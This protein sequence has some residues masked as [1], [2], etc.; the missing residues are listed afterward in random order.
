L[1]IR[2]A[3]SELRDELLA[4]TSNA[5]E[6]RLRVEPPPI[7]LPV[8]PQR[9]E[10]RRQLGLA[11]HTRLI[12]LVARLIPEKRVSEALAAVAYLPDVTVVVV[13]GGP[14]QLE[15]SA[16]FGHVRFTG[17]LPRPVA[18]ATCRSELPKMPG[19]G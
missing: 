18:L 5:L 13:G 10:A 2:C 9:G 15:L 6:H 11:E 19:C 8:R 3:S 12:V 7:E 16:R 14:L 4:C 1:S 17:E